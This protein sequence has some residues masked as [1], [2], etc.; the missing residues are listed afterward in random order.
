MKGVGDVKRF[1]QTTNSFA[2]STT[3]GVCSSCAHN[4]VDTIVMVSIIIMCLLCLRGMA[5]ILAA[6]LVAILVAVIMEEKV[7]TPKARAC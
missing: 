2:T 6:I 1:F 3:C 5:V 7:K 4:V